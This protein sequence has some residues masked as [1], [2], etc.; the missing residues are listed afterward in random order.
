[1]ELAP[2]GS[3][4]AATLPAGV[5]AAFAQALLVGDAAGAAACFASSGRLLTADGTEVLG[6]P[7][8]ADVL[9]QLVCSEVRLEIRLGRT[10]MAG[11]VA[12]ATQYWKRSSPDGVASGFEQRTKATLVLGREADGWAILIASPWG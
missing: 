8:I 2:S 5:A 6:G 11:G 1:L 12:L 4:T 7:A 9:A 10:V 3:E